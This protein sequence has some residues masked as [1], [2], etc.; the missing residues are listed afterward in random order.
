MKK[1][2]LV[3]LLTVL[4]SCE[5][6]KSLTGLK[7]I[8]PDGAKTIDLQVEIAD[9]EKL[10]QLGLMYRKELPEKEGMLFI[11]SDEQPRSFWMK[12]TFLELDMLFFDS[13]KKLVSIVKRATPLTETRR[14]SN[15]PA[16]YVLEVIGG[17]ADKWGVEPGYRFE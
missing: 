10:R 7:L 9:N 14:D 1:L 2:L 16:E 17:S 11:F 13:K 5:P 6:S 4:S 3:F 8:S 12:N 15:L